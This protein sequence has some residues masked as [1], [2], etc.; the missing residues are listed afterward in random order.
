MLKAE[1]AQVRILVEGKAPDGTSFFEWR[2]VPGTELRFEGVELK[3]GETLTIESS[4]RRSVGQ[5]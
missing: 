4:L 1:Q 5:E 2:D 3:N